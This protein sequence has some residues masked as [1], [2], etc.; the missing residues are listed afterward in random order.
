MILDEIDPHQ[1]FFPKDKRMYRHHCIL[2]QS[3]TS[4]T[5]P[6]Y[7]KDLGVIS[8]RDLDDL[9]IVD[10][11]ILSFA[12]HLDNGIPICSYTGGVEDQE[13][14]YLIT[15]LEEVYHQRDVRVSNKKTFRLSEILGCVSP[16]SS[17]FSE[18][19]GPL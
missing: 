10:N 2:A 12:F 15:Y 3:N 14:L 17:P 19:G 6:T 11:S 5:N 13:L 16:M 1:K 4:S 8:D 7:V 18:A 9:L